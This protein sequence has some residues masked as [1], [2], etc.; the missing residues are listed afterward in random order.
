[1]NVST[2]L[3]LEPNG[4]LNGEVSL[5]R[6]PALHAGPALP[7]LGQSR[8][9][10]VEAVETETVRVANKPV[11]RSSTSK[12]PPAHGS[13]PEGV[14]TLPRLTTAS[15]CPMV[16]DSTTDSLSLVWRPHPRAARRWSTL[17]GTAVSTRSLTSR[18]A[19]APKTEQYAGVRT[20]A[21]EPSRRRLLWVFFISAAVWVVVLVQ[22]DRTD[23]HLEL[24][25]LQWW[26]V[27]AVSL[28]ML[29][30]AAA[31]RLASEYGPWSW[32]PVVRRYGKDAAVVHLS[33]S[34]VVGLYLVSLMFR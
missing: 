23:R 34:L 1:M 6:A 19:R 9:V 7:T 5:R 28:G 2:T 13:F 20:E 16:T 32:L 8:E 25:E 31:V 10:L 24:R 18:A 30:S 14:T 33:L 17:S 29:G 26:Q 4:A 22:V 21:D 11:D 15:P 27:A 3:P 12:D